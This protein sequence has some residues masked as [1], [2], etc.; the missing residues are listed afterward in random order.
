MVDFMYTSGYE[1][2][3]MTFK[4]RNATIVLADKKTRTTKW[5]LKTEYF[6]AFP[7]VQNKLL[8]HGI[9]LVFIE[10][11][12][13][14]CKDADIEIKGDFVSYLH[15]EFGFD[16]RCI[17][18][19][20]SAGGLIGIKFAAKYPECVSVLYLDAPV[21]NLLSC[22]LSLGCAQKNDDMIAEFCS[23][24]NTNASKLLC[25]RGQPIDVMHKLL[26]NKLPIILV[27]GLADTVVPY[28]ENGKLL[29]DYYKANSGEIKQILKDNCGHHPHGLDDPSEIVDFI[30][31]YA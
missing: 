16:L 6:T 17:I 7:G 5:A 28:C 20:M 4:E 23:A 14:W 1:T 27:C 25:Y 11:E 18:I 10:N 24:M 2:I 15:T 30:L 12:T 9:N 21:L 19:G 3:K 26:E 29:Y 8:E 13:R 31:K 22:P